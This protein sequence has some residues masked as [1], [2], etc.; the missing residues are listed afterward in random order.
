MG[1]LLQTTLYSQSTQNELLIYLKKIITC[2]YLKNGQPYEL[3]TNFSIDDKIYV[4][5]SWE[6]VRGS[7]TVEAFWYD[8]QNKLR[9][10]SPVAFKSPNGFYNSWFWF[11]INQTT[12]EKHFASISSVDSMGNW[13]VDIYLDGKFIQK[14]DFIVG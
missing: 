6:N 11:K 7:H 1:T 2:K 12:W 3:A 9:S 14:L 8:S 13:H 5:A 4:F 10:V